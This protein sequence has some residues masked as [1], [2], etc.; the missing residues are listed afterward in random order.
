VE[1]VGFD[2]YPAGGARVWIRPF[3]LV[4]EMLTGRSLGWRLRRFG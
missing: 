2:R 4:T 3:L 1:F